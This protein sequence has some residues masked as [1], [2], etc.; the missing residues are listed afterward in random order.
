MAAERA[1]SRRS[2]PVGA[3]F[4]GTVIRAAWLAVL[5]GIV[6]QLLLLAV[7]AGFSVFRGGG[8]FVAETVRNVAWSV[9]VCAG[10]AA[11]RTAAASRIEFTGL[12]GMLAAPLGLNAANAIQKAVAEALDVA[13]PAPGGPSPFLVALI[14]AVEYG[15]LGLAVAWLGS[16]KQAGAGT[17]AVVGLIAGVVFGGLILLL[18]IGTSGPPPAP[19][20]VSRAANEILFPVGCALVIYVTGVVGGSLSHTE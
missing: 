13:Q 10:L 15:S 12:T 1:R 5:L 3:D 17:Y 8:P 20:I 6:L 18:V 16:R 2:V 7:A 9:I 14:K 4:W 11:G 19:A